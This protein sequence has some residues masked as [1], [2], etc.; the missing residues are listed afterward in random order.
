MAGNHNKSVG[1]TIRYK[2]YYTSGGWRPERGLV[3]WDGKGG[4][5]GCRME[6]A[7]DAFRRAGLD[8]MPDWLVREVEKPGFWGSVEFWKRLSEKAKDMMD[9]DTVRQVMES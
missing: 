1:V 4:Y 8:K 6:A 9:L 7:E 5:K 2:E 3:P